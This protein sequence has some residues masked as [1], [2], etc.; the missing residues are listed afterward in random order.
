MVSIV[1]NLLRFGGR[2]QRDGGLGGEQEESE[3]LLQVQTDRGIVVVVRDP[4]KTPSL[5]RR[6][7]SPPRVV[8]TKAPVMAGAQMI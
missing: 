3:C 4:M 6:S 5:M 2:N 1:S 7:K 8:S